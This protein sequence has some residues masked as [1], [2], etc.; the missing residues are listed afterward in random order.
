MKKTWTI[1]IAVLTTMFLLGGCGE[2]TLEEKVAKV[3][4]AN[5][6][7]TQDVID[8][9]KLEGLEV[10][11]VDTDATFHEKWPNAVLV[12]V[13]DTHYVALKSFEENLW[14]R[15]KIRRDMGWESRFFVKPDDKNAAVNYI[16]Y[17]YV[18]ENSDH[19]VASYELAAKNIVALI[20]P[21]YPLDISKKSHTEQLVEIKRITAINDTLKN[22][23]Y[24]HINAMIQ[25]EILLETENF[26]I[27]GTLS[28]YAT[29]IV[30]KLAEREW[31]YYDARTWLNCDI[32]CSDAF[33][34][35]YEGMEYKVEVGR[36][37][38]WRNSHGNMSSSGILEAED[39][40]ID[41][42]SC[43]T[44]DVLWSEPEGKPIYILTI[45]IG[46]DFIETIQLDPNVIKN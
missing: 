9:M 23:F 13:N 46:D 21:V 40:S 24:N 45:T 38:N 42:P 35:Q 15:E 41:L 16:G 14:E 39:R 33:M 19:W 28:Y 7:T 34:E 1:L 6:I 29:G 10:K 2:M 36:P 11:E 37:D 26:T 17:T 27:S 44:E 20:V 12:Q 30:D 31:I 25:E 32:V 22:I 4:K 18:S 43:N 8:L 3:Q 5:T